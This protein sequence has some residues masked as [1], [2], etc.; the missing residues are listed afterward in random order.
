MTEQPITITR[1]P[2]DPPHFRASDGAKSQDGYWWRT[3]GGQM[4][5]NMP[6]YR[7]AFDAQ[8][9]TPTTPEQPERAKV[10]DWIVTSVF[11][12]RMVSEVTHSHIRISLSGGTATWINHGDYTIVSPPTATGDKITERDGVW[13]EERFKSVRIMVMNGKVIHLIRDDN[14]WGSDAKGRYKDLTFTLISTDPAELT[15][16]WKGVG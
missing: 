3:D 15:K 10:G 4:V 1:V 2:S 11:G 5:E 14:T 9:L 7:A 13:E 6:S 16:G 8:I 12:E